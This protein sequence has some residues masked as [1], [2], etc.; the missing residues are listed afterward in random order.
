MR[1]L[2]ITFQIT[3]IL[4]RST[5]SLTRILLDTD[6]DFRDMDPDTNMGDSTDQSSRESNPPVPPRHSS[7]GLS[8]DVKSVSVQASISR[9]SSP[10]KSIRKSS[11]PTNTA[12]IRYEWERSSDNRIIPDTKD[13]KAQFLNEK[14]LWEQREAELR[15]K[16]DELEDR[17]R[18]APSSE[19]FQELQNMLAVEQGLREQTQD[20][21]QQ[22]SMEAEETRKR[23][24]QAARELDKIRAQSQGFYQVTDNYLI[25]LTTQLRYNIRS[26]AIQYFGGEVPSSVQIER[27]DYWKMYMEFTTRATRGHE[28]YLLSQKK[29]HSI[30]QAFLWRFLVDQVFDKFRWAG[31]AGKPLRKLCKFVRPGECNHNSTCM[32][33]SRD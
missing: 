20:E 18:N 14:E 11:I 10:E 33:Q 1:G 15:S 28:A 4:G 2:D 5:P 16:I 26:F 12:A 25:E 23:W 27:T 9:S 6:L 30:I 17:N 21:L 22:R 13:W 3:T 24:K 31:D 8:R 32:E 19:A 29:C 7:M